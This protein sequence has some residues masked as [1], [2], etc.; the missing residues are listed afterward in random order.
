M[1]TASAGTHGELAAAI[2]RL[3]YRVQAADAALAA[4]AEEVD[5]FRAAQ[6]RYDDAVRR[7]EER[8]RAVEAARRDVTDLARQILERM[9]GLFDVF[10]ADAPDGPL[11]PH[12]ADAPQGA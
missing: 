9:D 5:V 6:Q 4:V 7:Q 12:P 1:A 3:T 11:D 2:E 8:R 10:G